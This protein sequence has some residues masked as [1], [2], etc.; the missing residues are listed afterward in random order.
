MAGPSGIRVFA[1]RL[2]EPSETALGLIVIYLA[3]TYQTPRFQAGTI[4]MQMSI[5]K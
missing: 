5:T 2:P 3:G 1:Q 4:G